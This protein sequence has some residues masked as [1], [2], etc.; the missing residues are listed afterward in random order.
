MN[1]LTCS[2]LILFF[3]V[4]ALATDITLLAGYQFNSDFEIASASDLPPGNLPA[5]AQPGDDVEL[6][7]SASFGLAV[8]FVYQ[9]DPTKR[10]GFYISQQQTEFESNAGLTNSDVDVTH[11][12]F[13]AMS[14]Y[15]KGKWEPFVL[16]GIGAGRFSPDDSTLD[17]ET[18][19]SAQIGAGTNYQLS[20]NLL[21]RADIRWLG[22]FFDSDGE[23]LCSGGC[24][25][26]ISS[27]V[28]SQVQANLGLS[29]RF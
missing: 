3:T 2:L 12:H 19:F 13:T 20:E 15:P 1:R 25:V 28:Y 5:S 29:Y 10:M 7:E 4:P 17:D 8:D 24:T 26:A 22:T 23:A 16:A 9:Q 27:T 14:Y 11:V 18:K 21:L 6:D